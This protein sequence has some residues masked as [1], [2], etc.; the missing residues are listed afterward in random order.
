MTVEEVLKSWT[1]IF[2]KNKDLIHNLIKNISETNKDFDFV[3][4]RKDDS[5]FFLIIPEL[6]NINEILNKAKDRCVNIVVLNIKKNLDFII[7]NWNNLKTF[8]NL[9]FY[10]VNPNAAREQKWILYPYSH[11]LIIETKN[12]KKSLLTLFSTVPA[13]K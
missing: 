7:N 10:F 12:I 9:C 4:H 1:L 11:D 8:Q 13:Y 5:I 3:V 2:V 6:S